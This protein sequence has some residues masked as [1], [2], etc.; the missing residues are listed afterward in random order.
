M[1]VMA[2][3]MMP[4]T[5]DAQVEG[6]DPVLR[7]LSSSSSQNAHIENL[8]KWHLISEYRHFTP[9]S[10]TP[11]AEIPFEQLSAADAKKAQYWYGATRIHVCINEESVNYY[12]R[13]VYPEAV[14]FFGKIATDSKTS[15]VSAKV[16]EKKDNLEE[17][18]NGMTL[19]IADAVE[20]LL[21]GR[22]CKVILIRTQETA[23]ANLKD[24]QSVRCEVTIFTIPEAYKGFVVNPP[25]SYGKLVLG[26]KNAQGGHVGEL[27]KN[28]GIGPF[29]HTNDSNIIF[30]GFGVDYARNGDI[31]LTRSV[32]FDRFFLYSKPAGGSVKFD[33]KWEEPQNI[34][35]RQKAEDKQRTYEDN[36]PGFW[37]YLA[38]TIVVLVWLSL[39]Y[40]IWVLYQESKR[41]F[42]PLTS[43]ESNSSIGNVA[44]NMENADKLFEETGDFLNTLVCRDVDG[45]SI[46]FY[47]KR[48]EI[49][50]G[51]ELL[52]RLIAL[53]HKTA[54]QIELIN[55][56]GANLNE[57]QHRYRSGSI[58]TL[59]GAVVVFCFIGFMM[60]TVGN[61]ILGAIT[62]FGFA[63]IYYLSTLCP[64]YKL[65]N[66]EP[67]YQK[68][69]VFI[70]KLTGLGSLAVAAS[71]AANEYGRV[72]RDSYGNLYKERDDGT[73]CLLGA[74]I[75]CFVLILS[76]F[77]FMLNNICSFFR[78]YLGNK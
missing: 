50:K 34:Q 17:K 20:P 56:L 8:K 16:R 64:A 21:T 59:I 66:P 78:N 19:G 58:W 67:V 47:T 35:A 4:Q 30:H 38:L 55:E 31:Y 57:A 42:V 7:K 12:N 72:Y 53:P 49:N 69:F 26:I 76:P 39:P 28:V 32:L 62:W 60:Y 2:L 5:A 24:G 54:E 36:Q 41:R 63:I 77:L 33:L 61:S 15:T 48:T 25:S 68:I 46:A 3:G 74:I 14:K 65:A 40:M 70:L 73:G 29:M 44:L 1:A 13:V 45:E 22:G 71:M 18:S 23:F 51:Y 27:E 6:R 75:A 11:P 10:F 37:T 52:A 9:G 43:L